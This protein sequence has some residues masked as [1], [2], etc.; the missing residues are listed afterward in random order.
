MTRFQSFS[1]IE[2]GSNYLKNS[3]SHTTT[4]LLQNA[5]KTIFVWLLICSCYLFPHDVT[6]RY[7]P[8]HNQL[9]LC[10]SIINYA[11]QSHITDYSIYIINY[12][13]Y[14]QVVESNYAL[15][16]NK[17]HMLKGKTLFFYGR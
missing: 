8:H 4:Y 10:L 2:I 15:K 3:E 17:A 16:K 1:N 13:T 9:C 12:M 7:C 11:Y 6:C 5:K 14:F